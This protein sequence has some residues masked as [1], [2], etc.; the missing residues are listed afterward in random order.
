MEGENKYFCDEYQRKVNAMKRCCIKS[1]RNTVIINLKRFDFN[2]NTY[3][4]EKLND[5]CS[6]PINLNLKP[7]S[8]EGIGYPG[9]ELG[10]EKL[11]KMDK[12]E[13][14]ENENTN[15]EA[16]DDSYYMY[17]LAGVLVH[18]GTADGGH[19]YSY[20]RERDTTSP[21]YNKWIEF[22]DSYI[23]T[24]DIKDMPTEC[25]GGQTYTGYYE[26]DKS[27]NAYMLFYQRINPIPITLNLHPHK[28]YIYIYIIK[29]P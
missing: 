3:Q 1:L 13:N 18:S 7:W 2:Y 17:A 5:Y 27:S 23:S 26:F 14:V 16:K 4:R 24:F 28:V 21:N 8:K 9:E 25:F 22:N 10:D 20:I 15:I 19:Y 29:N 12:L 6:F 11:Y